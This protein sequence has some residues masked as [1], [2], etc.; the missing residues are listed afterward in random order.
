MFKF[1]KLQ[2]FTVTLSFILVKK[3]YSFP[4]TFQ[5]FNI[6]WSGIMLFTQYCLRLFPRPHSFSVI[7][8]WSFEKSKFSLFTYN[9]WYIFLFWKNI[10]SQMYISVK[11]VLLNTSFWSFLALIKKTA[12]YLK[13]EY[14]HGVCG[15]ISG[16]SFFP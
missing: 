13:P 12:F 15:Y 8:C 3:K 10:V 7:L 14:T 9:F 1:P 11:Y 16:I 5:K 4:K 2:I 6:F